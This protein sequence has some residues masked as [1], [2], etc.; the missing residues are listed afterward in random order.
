MEIRI[1]KAT[2][3]KS[4]GGDLGL[5]MQELSFLL[6]RTSKVCVS[7]AAT[8]ELSDFQPICCL[9]Y[10]SSKKIV[11]FSCLCGFLNFLVGVHDALKREEV[12]AEMILEINDSPGM[13]GFLRELSRAN[14]FV[15]KMISL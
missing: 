11:L 9:L 8:R 6:T 13:R 5:M 12:E 7:V 15:L 14:D 2:G 1:G 3:C 10:F 4:T